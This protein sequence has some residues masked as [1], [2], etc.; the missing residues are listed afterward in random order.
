MKYLNFGAVEAIRD[1]AGLRAWELL[2]N[3]GYREFV[4][5]DSQKQECKIVIARNKFLRDY[6]LLMC[7][8][9]PH[10]RQIHDT[11]KFHPF[12]LKRGGTL[13]LCL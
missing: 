8:F 3:K 1:E 5:G 11:P 4:V 10:P 13:E 2:Y 7:L 6:F 12:F 9:I